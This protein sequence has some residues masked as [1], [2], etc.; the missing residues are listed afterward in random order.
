MSNDAD[1]EKFVQE[2]K[3][4]A[5]LVEVIERTSE[6]RFGKRAGRYTKCIKPDSLMVDTDWGVYT[7]FAHAGDAGHQF[8]TGDVFHWLERHNGMGFWDAA[9]YLAQLFNVR[10]PEKARQVDPEK[11]RASKTRQEAFEI[12]CQWFERQLWA[13][14]AAVDY[15]HRRGWTDETIRKARLGLA[16]GFD[17]LADLRGEMTMNNVNLD[18]AATVAIVGRRG[19]VGEWITSQ[20]IQDANPD[21]IS[22]NYV[23]GLAGGLR[24]VY[25]HVWR[26]RVVYFSARNLLMEGGRLINRPEKDEQGNHKPKSYNLPRSLAGERMRYFNFAYTRGAKICLVVEGQPDAI[27]AAQAGIGALALAGV[28][29]DLS[30]VE[31]IKAQKIERLFM[32]LDNDEAGQKN[33][34]NA[35]AQFGPLTRLVTWPSTV[36]EKDDDDDASD[37]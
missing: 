19:G 30:L 6:Y 12:A 35:A 37:E 15:C 32:G 31:L 14:P 20:G 5:D 29:A 36:V 17:Q 1:F 3:D 9:L 18:D 22:G 23:P 24:L 27:S 28:A 34:I 25:P 8:E 26:G 33:Q 2:L 16:P 7:W 4:R 10:V 11:A 13:S 21:W